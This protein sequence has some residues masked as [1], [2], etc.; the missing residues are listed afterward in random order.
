[1]ANLFDEFDKVNYQE[2]IEKATRDMK[3]I[4]PV[5]SFQIQLSSLQPMLPKT[6]RGFDNAR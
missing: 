4:D 5:E 3:G 2:W 6:T 1:M